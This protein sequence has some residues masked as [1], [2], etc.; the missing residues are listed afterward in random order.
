MKK[1]IWVLLFL[2]CFSLSLSTLFREDK[3][4]KR[5]GENTDNILFKI[6]GK[7]E[8]EKNKT[9]KEYKTN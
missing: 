4:T 9:E 6:E 8:G 3:K 1:S 2:E 7:K 5:E